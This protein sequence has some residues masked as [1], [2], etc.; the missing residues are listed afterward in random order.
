MNKKQKHKKQKNKKQK[1]RKQI[2]RMKSIHQKIL[3]QL[4]S[5]YGGLSKKKNEINIT[6]CISSALTEIMDKYRKLKKK[7]TNQ[8]KKENPGHNNGKEGKEGNH[9]LNQSTGTGITNTH[10][11]EFVEVEDIAE[12]DI[13]Y[14]TPGQI[15]NNESYHTSNIGS[16]TEW[17][18]LPKLIDGNVFTISSFPP[19]TC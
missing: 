5:K 15:P 11:M 4:V 12:I 9:M 6:E 3:K 10:D 13:D 7:E 17:Y 1:N 8:Q 2:Q 16:Y 19:G 18:Q 14:H